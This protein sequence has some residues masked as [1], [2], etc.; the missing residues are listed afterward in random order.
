MYPDMVDL[1]KFTRHLT[2]QVDAMNDL[3]SI[4]RSHD[5]F[6]VGMACSDMIRNGRFGFSAPFKH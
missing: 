4:A 3:V 5:I 6:A 1:G 2:V